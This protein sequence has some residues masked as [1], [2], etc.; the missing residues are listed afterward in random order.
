MLQPADTPEKA[1]SSALNALVLTV[2]SQAGGRALG[3][4]DLS[5]PP[6]SDQHRQ[7]RQ[8]RR[9]R[10]LGIG[11]KRPIKKLKA[12]KTTAA[13]KQRMT[14]WYCRLIIC[15]TLCPFLMLVLSLQL[16]K[17]ARLLRC[18]K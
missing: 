18:L 3:H 2:E 12:N 15:L 8:H 1:C 4:G 13:K 17:L 11:M 5:L 14:A 9:A 10:K 7:H 16:V 6:N